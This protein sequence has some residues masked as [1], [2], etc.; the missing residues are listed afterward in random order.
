MSDAAL[1]RRIEQLEDRVAELEDALGMSFEM[2]AGFRIAGGSRKQVWRL[3]CALA[4]RRSLTRDQAMIVLYSDRDP[5]RRPE[6]KIVDVLICGA[7]HFARAHG[8]EIKT[9]RGCGWF[10]DCEARTRATALIKR[11]QAS[12]AA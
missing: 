8:V 9:N 7:R 3:F 6:A 5:D 10:L 12:E 11:L 2:P 1:L 4:K